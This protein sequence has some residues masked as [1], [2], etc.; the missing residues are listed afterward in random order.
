MTSQ[1]QCKNTSSTPYADD[2]AVLNASDYT[3]IAT[4]RIQDTINKVKDWTNK[5]ALKINK[6]KTVSIL[7]SLSTSK[8]Q[9]K[10]TLR[11]QP[12]HQVDTE[13]FPGATLDTRLTWKPHQE[14]VKA[15]TTKTFSLMKK[16]AGTRW[17]VN[18]N[19]LSQVY[20]GAVRPVA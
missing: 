8:E 15:R 9:V 19:I 17:D 18:A 2:F 10:L 12:V 14:A 20:T 7:F 1:Q 6:T 5:S 4:K 13:R 3:S 16:H 11:E